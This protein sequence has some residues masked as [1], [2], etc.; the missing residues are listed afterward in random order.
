VKETIQTI[1][2]SA[3]KS[4]GVNQDLLAESSFVVEH[5]TEL[6]KGDYST[7]AALAFGKLLKKN[8]VELA[9]VLAERINS[10]VPPEISKVETAG[11]GFINF[12]LSPAFLNSSI[13]EIMEKGSGF[14]SGELLS[15]K[16][17]F[18]EYT[19]P[20][21]FKDF[22]IG[23]LMNNA[24]GEA[25][26]RILE[27]NGAEVKR[28]TYHGD[29]GMHVAKT[30]F[31]LQALKKEV[32]IEALGEA[33]PHGNTAYE[34]DEQ[35]KKEI[36]DI[37]KKI[38]EK[39]DSEINALYEK[40]REVSL[41][42][43][44]SMYARLGSAF[45]FH[46]YESEAGQIGREI[47]ESF[48]GPVFE[49]SQGAVIFP[50][51]KYDLHTRVFLNAEGLPTYETKEVGLAKIKK[52][53]YPYDVSLTIT[54]NEQDDFFKVV[55][56]VIGKVFPELDNK[57]KHLSHGV[58]KL[59]TGKMSSRTG[60]VISAESFIDEVKGGVL[61]KMDEA[62]RNI[63]EEEKPAV[64]EKVALGAI[65]YWILKQSIGKDIIFDR[66]KALS[67][68]GD[69]GPYIQY[70]HTRALSVLRKAEEQGIVLDLESE[71][72][73]DENDL[74]KKLYRFPEI[75]EES[76]KLFAPQQVVTYL[77]D[78][79]ATFNNFYAHHQVIVGNDPSSGKRVALVAAFA[80]VMENGMKVLG[81]IPPE[82][83]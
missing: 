15:G 73:L 35:A 63:S 47:V 36:T 54:A 7:N 6:S 3:L 38:Y 43:F 16:K 4:E 71:L 41:S 1:V 42:Y 46:F 78:L 11:P 25:L 48:I 44:E 75:I 33:Y 58:L 76:A 65:K 51:E 40:G 55:E 74:T 23:H 17:Y 12:F 81:I 31:G 67:L 52:E 18:I 13:A 68:E 22:H 83:M 53:T 8:P 26:S 5:P 70:A 72:V 10:E 61:Q 19:Q 28:A 57:L 82:K 50:G 20:N 39:S 60:G 59:T 80:T 49:K 21:P 79:A 62:E 69:S 14:G 77:I 34:Q 32:S 30:I 64:A 45:D 29:V 56:V 9:K 66:E 24:I 27:K 37:N 2:I